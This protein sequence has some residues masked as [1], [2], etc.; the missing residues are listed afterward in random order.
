MFALFVVE[1]KSKFVTSK[2]AKTFANLRAI[3]A[4]F[5]QLSLCLNLALVL[6]SWLVQVLQLLWHYPKLARCTPCQF[7]ILIQYYL[8]SVSSSL[9]SSLLSSSSNFVL[10]PDVVF[11]TSS[12]DCFPGGYLK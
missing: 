4:S 11:F 7:A 9:S 3:L 2:N 10:F 1:M 8:S 6:A 5:A 12:I